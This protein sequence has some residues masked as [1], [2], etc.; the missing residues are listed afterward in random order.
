MILCITNN[1]IYIV[2]FTSLKYV[3]HELPYEI[4]S[5]IISWSSIFSASAFNKYLSTPI[6]NSKQRMSMSLSDFR[7]KYN[8]Y[9]ESK[10]YINYKFWTKILLLAN[11]F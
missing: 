9:V 2:I 7:C 4:R 8:L 6:L 5:S 10:Y 3:T 11:S 1:L